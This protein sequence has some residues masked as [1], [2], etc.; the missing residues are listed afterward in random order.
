M[1]YIVM[2]NNLRIE[3]IKAGIS[4]L[5]RGIMPRNL[6]FSPCIFYGISS[7]GNLVLNYNGDKKWNSIGIFVDNLKEQ[8][9]LH[10]FVYS[11]NNSDIEVMLHNW[12]RFYELI[13][14]LK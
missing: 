12:K 5:E 7:L 2:D 1:K 14:D 10:G 9:E 6:I 8:M 3:R 4:F 11:E 13:K